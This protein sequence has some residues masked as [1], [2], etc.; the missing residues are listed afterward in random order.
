MMWRGGVLVIRLSGVGSGLVSRRNRS[1]CPG[2]EIWSGGSLAETGYWGSLGYG[3]LRRLW[4]LWFA[5]L[6]DIML[7]YWWL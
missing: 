4:D 1:L 7:A 5:L 2:I 6:L 3:G